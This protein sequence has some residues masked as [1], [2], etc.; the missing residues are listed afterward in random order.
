[1][2]RKVSFEEAKARYT[3][4]YTC[5]HVPAWARKINEGNGKYYAPQFTTDAEW[6]SNT[7]FRGEP[8]YLGIG[9]DCYTT[10]LTF[11]LGKW[12]DAPFR[13]LPV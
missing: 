13:G 1:M 6:Y 7:K 8:G 9:S 3:N 11:P 4:R 5:E 10:G 12:L 2:S